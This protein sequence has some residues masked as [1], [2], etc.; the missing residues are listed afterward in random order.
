MAELTTHMAGSLD[1]DAWKAIASWL[2]DTDIE[3]AEVSGPGWQVRLLRDSDYVA[4]HVAAVSTP[5]PLPDRSL[6]LGSRIVKVSAPVAGVFLDSHPLRTPPMIRIG[7]RVKAGDILALLQIGQLLVPVTAP[8]D[9]VIV[10]VL[11][12]EQTTVGYGCQLF[13]MDGRPM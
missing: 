3:C 9:G 7:S 5:P 6:S 2:A 8:A 11:V 10:R 4:R 12:D 1:D 13:E